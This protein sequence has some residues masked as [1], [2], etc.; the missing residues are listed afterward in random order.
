MKINVEEIKSYIKKPS[1][2][3]YVFDRVSSTNAVA[4]NLMKKK[5]LG[6]FVI[7]A[8]EQT[9]GKGQ[10]GRD[11]CSLPGGLYLSIGCELKIAAKNASHITLFSA[12]SIA[13]KLRNYQL[14][15]KL[16]WP[17]DLVIEHQKLGGIKSEIKIRDNII[18]QGIIGIGINWSNMVPENGI[19]LQSYQHRIIS[20]EHLAAI[21][22]EAIISGYQYY[23]VS[24]IEVLLK[25][26]MEILDDIGYKTIIKDFEG[27]ISGV[28]SEGNLEI[29][30]QVSKI[31][32]TINLYSGAISL[33]YSSRF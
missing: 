30:S 7:I 16:K 24:G 18:T 6:F 25:N 27:I 13:N 14:P 1:Y 28:N 21:V 10:W 8:S 19:N 4:W 32:T 2:P 22:I 12:W 15:V 26:Y 29:S 17:N 31:M 23:L 5:E 9:K 3:I 33:G 11:W 20:I